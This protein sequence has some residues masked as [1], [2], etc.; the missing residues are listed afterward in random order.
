MEL[1]IVV[2]LLDE[3]DNV[4]PLLEQIRHA[5][6]GFA[7]E[8]I[9]VDDGSTDATVSQIKR[10]ADERVRLVVLR[11]NHG[12]TAAMAAGIAEATGSYIATMDGDLQN[13][14]SDIPFMLQ[15]LIDEDWD[16]IAGNRK[17]R[18]DGLL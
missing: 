4:K 3:Q 14:P 7:Y 1:S 6:D 13:D 16:V 5:L 15:K 8:V 17:A 12:Q 9:L 11:G 2:T 10:F 18:Q